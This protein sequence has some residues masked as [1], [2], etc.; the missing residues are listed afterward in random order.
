M[1]LREAVPNHGRALHAGRESGP[2][3]FGSQF[4]FTPFLFTF[5]I[6]CCSSKDST[7]PPVLFLNFSA[8]D[9]SSFSARS[10]ECVPWSAKV[11][12]AENSEN[13]TLYQIAGHSSRWSLAISHFSH[14]VRFRNSLALRRST[15]LSLNA[16]HPGGRLPSKSIKRLTEKIPSRHTPHNCDDYSRTLKETF[17]G[18]EKALA[19]GALA[20][21]ANRYTR[22]LKIR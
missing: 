16:S 17:E 14:R 8:L 15:V 11:I 6:P 13:S 21:E 4:A 5:P 12:A 9:Y 3:L 2:T 7:S 19:A 18:E 1:L 20:E 22:K 10:R